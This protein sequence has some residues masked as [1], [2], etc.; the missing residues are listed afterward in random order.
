M[1]SIAMKVI[2]SVIVSYIIFTREGRGKYFDRQGTA[3]VR[4]ERIH[5]LSG[6]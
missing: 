6:G 3:A 4:Q 5:G 1:V 2:I